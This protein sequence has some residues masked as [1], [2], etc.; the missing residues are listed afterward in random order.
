MGGREI[1]GAQ[2]HPLVK[3]RWAG[4]T[5][6]GR[7]HAQYME[8]MNISAGGPKLLV[9]GSTLECRAEA[10]NVIAMAHACLV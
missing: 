2:R 1:S 8:I 5:R 10:L 4:A 6:R 7:V 9:K 3:D